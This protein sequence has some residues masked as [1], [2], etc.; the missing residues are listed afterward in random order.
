MLKKLIHL[1]M[2]L[3]FFVSGCVVTWL[4]LHGEG[5]ELISSAQ[6]GSCYTIMKYTNSTVSGDDC[7]YT[8]Q[9]DRSVKSINKNTKTV[10]ITFDNRCQYNCQRFNPASGTC[11]GA[12]MNDC[13]Y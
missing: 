2:A 1:S 8:L 6:A 5:P 11:V 3:F 12:R 7:V 4:Y 9:F 13:N 10:I